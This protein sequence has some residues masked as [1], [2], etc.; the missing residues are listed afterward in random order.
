[1]ARRRLHTNPGRS[2]LL[3]PGRLG[4]LVLIVAAIWIGSSFAQKIYVAYRLNAEVRT[5]QRE[6]DRLAEANKGYAGQLAAMAKPQGAEEQARLHNYV[7]P[8]EKVYVVA[9]PP[10][11]SPSPSRSPAPRSNAASADQ[12]A[13]FWQDLWQAA[14]SAFSGK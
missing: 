14:S 10:T 6:N 11:P 12:S 13:G 1:L 4:I 8:D 9:A 3:S 5:L 7:K 2:G